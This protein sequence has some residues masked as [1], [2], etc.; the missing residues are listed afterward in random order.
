MFLVKQLIGLNVFMVISKEFIENFIC[1][2][3]FLD[4][5]YEDLSLEDDDDSNNN[6]KSGEVGGLFR[7]TQRKKTNIN[8]QEDYTLNTNSNDKHNWD[9]DEVKRKD[10]VFLKEFMRNLLFRFVI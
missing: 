6:K 10:L 3:F 2:C 8:D 9:L 1:F 4:E 7:V 5:G